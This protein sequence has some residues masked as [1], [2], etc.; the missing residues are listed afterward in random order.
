MLL[1]RAAAAA[2]AGAWAWEIV[3]NQATWTSSLS[4]LLELSVDFDGS[5][6]SVVAMLHP[7]DRE[8]V[9]RGIDEALRTGSPYAA[10]TRALRRGGESGWLQLNVEIVREGDRNLR[11]LGTVVDIDSRKRAERARREVEERFAKMFHSSPLSVTISALDTGRLLDV[12]EAF[13]KIAGYSREE[14]LGRTTVELGLW[15]SVEDRDAVMRA[16]QEFGGVRNR[17]VHMLARNGEDRVG[18]LSAERI[19]ID[20]EPYVL[21]QFEDITVRERAQTAL[22]ESEQRLRL[23]LRAA[24]A[25]VWQMETTTGTTSWSNEFREVYGYDETATPGIDTWAAHLHPEDRERMLKDLRS[26]L[27]PGTDE[28]RRE[29]RILHPTRGLRWILALGQIERNEQGRA[30]SM[31]GISIDITR[32]KEVEQELREAD[33]RKNEFLAVLS[34]ELR[35]P[36][37]PL[38]NGIEILRLTNGSGEIAE[39]ARVMM[40]RQLEQM[41][42]LIDDL[43]EVSRISRGKIELKREAVDLAVALQHALEVSKPLID[44]AGHTLSVDIPATALLVHADT[45]RLAQVFGNLLNNAAKYTPAGGH[46]WLSVSRTE[47]HVLVSIRDNGIGIAPEKLPKIFE[48]F[49][50]LDNSLQRTQGGL[51]IGLS[52]ARRLV[53]MHD[54]T[55]Q[56]RSE[57][58]G[59]GCEF[60]VKLPLYSRGGSELERTQA[61]GGPRDEVR[62]LRVLVADDNADAA[63]SL[64]LVLEMKGHEVR[65]AHDGREAVQV[66]ASFEPDVAVLDIGMPRLDGY[67]VCR[68]LR[69][70]PRGSKMLIVALTGWG[71][72]EDKQRSQQAGFDQHLVKPADVGALE[73]LLR[74]REPRS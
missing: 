20:G 64:A 19:T 67:E 6:E 73:E 60:I 44:S 70:Q 40:A 25:G 24:S 53:E 18:S 71:Q 22:R 8:R 51:G 4:D 45:T 59:K 50:Q 33:E 55:L 1:E 29:F 31:T 23:A 52:I 11:L 26:R 34:H 43:L 61:A 27:R 17:I 21:T 58:P 66:A 3:G 39:R 57:G 16:V 65:T 9:R 14:A 30:L 54:G 68:Q 38:R 32:I 12:S 74:Q 13:V 56:A 49:A 35:N 2:R 63:A 46:I 47:E 7:D 10:E 5:P 42:R 72:A 15:P 62:P 37:A 28:Y 69:A 48:M 36:L 41:V